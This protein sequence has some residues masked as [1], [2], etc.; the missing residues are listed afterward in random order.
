MNQLEKVLDKDGEEIEFPYTHSKGSVSI[1]IYR[2]PTRGCDSYT[3]SYWQD[4]VRKRPTFTTF[5]KALKE[6]KDVALKLGSASGDVLTLT[7]ADRATHLRCRE[8]AN[9]IGMPLE[10]IVSQ[11]V[12][13]KRILG[14]TPPV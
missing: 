11:M 2:T 6:A 4:G 8:L 14:D 12:E 1:K 9:Q 5:D 10:V 3:L 13:M 7:S